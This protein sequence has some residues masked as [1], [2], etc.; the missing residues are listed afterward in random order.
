MELILTNKVYRSIH[1]ECMSFPDLETGGI[2]IGKKVDD[3]CIVVPFSLGSGMK[4]L[5]TR[6][7]Y[8]PNVKWQQFYL[9]KLFNRYGVNY[10]GSYHRHPGNNCVP[11]AH[12]FK[13]ASQI[14]TDPEWNVA[15]AVFPIINLIGNKIIFYPY[16]FTRYSKRFQLVQ[17][18]IISSKDS[19]IKKILKRGVYETQDYYSARTSIKDQIER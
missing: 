9:E 14:V 2:L 7:R 1:D 5:R 11:S 3:K 10:V 15:E 8:S 13:A 18:H 17:W 12:D 6:I 19:L 4:T 16:Y